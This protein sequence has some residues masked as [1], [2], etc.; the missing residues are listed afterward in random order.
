MVKPF[1]K[2][3][4][5]VSIPEEVSNIKSGDIVDVYPLYPRNGLV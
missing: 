5:W 3:N 2:M 4:A 1:L